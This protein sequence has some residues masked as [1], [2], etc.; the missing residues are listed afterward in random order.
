EEAALR[1]GR[2][3]Q[4]VLERQARARL[5]LG[6]DVDEVERVRRG[7]DFL[8]VELGDLADRLENRAQLLAKALDLLVRQRQP[9]EPRDVEH[10]LT[11]DLHC[12]HPPKTKGPL[13]GALTSVPKGKL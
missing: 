2:V 10:L 9:R 6:E 7:R 1:V 12:K 3:R 11:T 8:E 13:S 5:V 4:R